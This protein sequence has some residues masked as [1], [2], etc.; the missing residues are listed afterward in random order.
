M[1]FNKSKCKVSHPGCGNPH[2]LKNERTEHSPAEKDLGI[3]LDG[4][5]DMSQQCG[6]IAQEANHILGCIKRSVAS[7]EME[8]IL[9]L[10]T[11]KASPEYCIQTWSPQYRRNMDLFGAH[12]EKGHKNEPRNETSLL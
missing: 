4:K 11:G 5:L 3:L 10:C 6:P 12:P 8:V 1:R 9:P 2:Y 7:R